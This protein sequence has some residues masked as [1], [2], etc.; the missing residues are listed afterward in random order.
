MEGYCRN[1]GG[2]GVGVTGMTRPL[3]G[4]LHAF[5]VLFL[6]ICREGGPNTAPWSCVP[7]LVRPPRF[8]PATSMPPSC[9]WT[10]V[11]G[12]LKPRGGRTTPGSF[13]GRL[14]KYRSDLREK[15]LGEANF[16]HPE[17]Q[18]VLLK[19][20]ARSP[21]RLPPTA[22]ASVSSPGDLPCGVASA[23]LNPSPLPRETARQGRAG[24]SSCFHSF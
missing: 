15:N 2:R 5:H 20:F 6:K 3:S 23:F 8:P 4:W 17:P 10:A 7:Y 18:Q 9:L 13:S 1:R 22:L 14:C 24:A 12:H 19:S 16:L 11:C 21:P